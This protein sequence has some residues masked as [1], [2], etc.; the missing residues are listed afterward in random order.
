MPIESQ[1]IIMKKKLR[2]RK[3]VRIHLRVKEVAQARK[4]EAAKLSR[5]ADLNYATVLALFN[6]PDRDVS[7][8]T[9]E[10]VARA[11]N[12]DIHDLYVVLLD[13]DK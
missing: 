5:M 10:K 6:K 12:V 2:S 7:I 13:D 3:L 1:G 8:L 4:I 9:L 11:L